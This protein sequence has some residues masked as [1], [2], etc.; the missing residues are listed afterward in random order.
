MNTELIEQLLNEKKIIMDKNNK[1]LEIYEN[2]KKEKFTE[3]KDMEN[4]FEQRKAAAQL[5]MKEAEQSYE[6]K[7]LF[8]KDLTQRKIDEINE[9]LNHE[10]VPLLN[11]LNQRIIKAE[12]QRE[13]SLEQL[14][15]SSLETTESNESEIIEMN[16]RH[17]EERAK[18]R[19]E[20]RQEKQKLQDLFYFFWLYL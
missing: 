3:L 17:Q 6:G 20:I 2:K 5:R 11:I 12:H 10:Y 18:L 9:K 16:K 14:H 7:L 19:A 1:E 15:K 8:E 13:I 4:E